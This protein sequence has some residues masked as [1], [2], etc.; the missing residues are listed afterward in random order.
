MTAN[1]AMGIIG[2]GIWSISICPDQ[3]VVK[4][5]LRHR[6]FLHLWSA[7]SDRTIAWSFATA[8]GTIIT[9]PESLQQN[10]NRLLQTRLEP[11][12]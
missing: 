9:L 12:D 6:R 1:T 10:D 4:D 3:A 7:G 2:C 8:R 11:D 5:S